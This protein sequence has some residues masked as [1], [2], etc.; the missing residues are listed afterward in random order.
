MR[1]QIPDGLRSA[2][3]WMVFPLVP[4]LLGQTS[5][6]TM[7]FGFGGG[8][9]PREWD[10]P[11]WT[12][13]LGPLLGYGYLAGATL[14]L[15]ENSLARGWRRWLGRRWVLVGV[16]PW[17]GFVSAAL[18]VFVVTRSLSAV[19]WLFPGADLSLPSFFSQGDE[20]SWA[21]WL[22]PRLAVIVVVAWV[23]YAWLIAAWTL[24]RRAQKLRIAAR[25]F[26]RGL[27]SALIFAGSLFG[28]FW[29]ITAVSRD[30]FF[31]RRIVPILILAC[32]LLTLSG[33]S[34]NLTYGEVRRRELFQ[35]LLLAWLVGMALA[36]RWWSRPR[37]KVSG[38]PHPP[39]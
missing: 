15:P 29:T 19:K 34:S 38:P 7:N 6:H 10:W 2:L 23:A 3:A 14:G 31:D 5:H 16:V 30:Y 13:L 22:T 24:N 25:C 27:A 20:N 11:A 26:Y 33:C 32:G 36:W 4:A 35:S 17:L 1:W 37:E 39:E 28:A 12:I 21:G 9:D 18:L 8:P